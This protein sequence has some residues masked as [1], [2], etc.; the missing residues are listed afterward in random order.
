MW[1]PASH[2]PGCYDKPVNYGWKAFDW[3]HW[4]SVAPFAYVKDAAIETVL[5][6]FDTV[7]KS[8][9]FQSQLAYMVDDSPSNETCS[10]TSQDRKA[11]EFLLQACLDELA[12]SPRKRH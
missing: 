2:C 3:N 12:T 4:S 5:R 11:K 9:S 1:W 6:E 7:S 10:T 8:E